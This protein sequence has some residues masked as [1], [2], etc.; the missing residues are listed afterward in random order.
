MGVPAQ[1]GRG[2][3]HHAFVPLR[4]VE[5]PGIGALEVRERERHVARRSV[6]DDSALAP[7]QVGGGT[8][9]DASAA[10]HV[11]RPRLTKADGVGRH[12]SGIYTSQDARFQAQGTCP[13]TRVSQALF[14]T[15]A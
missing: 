14:N 13:I 6:G 5:A 1:D 7:R 11:V 2:E 15:P 3:R 8:E 10:E 12:G 9:E 4:H